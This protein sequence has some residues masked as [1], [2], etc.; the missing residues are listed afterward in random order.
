[1]IT[2]RTYNYGLEK[3]PPLSSLAPV[4]YRDC[5]SLSGTS[6]VADSNLELAYIFLEMKIN[7]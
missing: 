4:Q 3:A 6:V 1:M 7:L 2:Q 5:G